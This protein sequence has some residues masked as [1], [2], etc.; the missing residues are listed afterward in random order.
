[1]QIKKTWMVM[2]KMIQV[3]IFKSKGIIHNQGGRELLNEFLKT[4]PEED[5]VKIE[6]YPS[7]IYML[8]FKTKTEETK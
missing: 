4:I 6:R 1:M 8:V 7:G 5:V 3:K 2:I